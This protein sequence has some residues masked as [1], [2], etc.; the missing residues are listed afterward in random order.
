MSE[1]FDNQSSE[2]S[3][4]SVFW[5]SL[6]LLIGLL[7]WSGYNDWI[8]NSQRIVYDTEY[9]QA[10]PTINQA[11]AVQKRYVALMKDLIETSAKDQAAAGIVKE[12]EA[13]GLLRQQ[14]AAPAAST[15]TNSASTPAAPAA[16]DTSAN[17]L[18]SSDSSK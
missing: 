7:I 10:I 4:Y 13:A 3:S 2:N 6:I 9:Q 1:E 8:Q 17:T 14:A 15:D 16:S 18:P 11:Q 12:A 5:P